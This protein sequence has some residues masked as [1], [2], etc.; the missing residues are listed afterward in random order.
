MTAATASPPGVFRWPTA[1]TPLMRK[2]SSGPA[3]SSAA[4]SAI[5]RIPASSYR[6]V[7][8][9]GVSQ[10]L[11]SD[12]PEPSSYALLNHRHYDAGPVRAPPPR[13]TQHR[14]HLLHHPVQFVV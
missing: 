9:M 4:R 11:M 7:A 8:G 3:L 1:L 12:S 10:S 5:R 2:S 13:L 14:S 6:N